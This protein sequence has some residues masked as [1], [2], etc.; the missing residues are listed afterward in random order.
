MGR[1]VC[2]MNEYTLQG[3]LIPNS[4]VHISA[5]IFDETRPVIRCTCEVYNF[6]Q[7]I[8]PD[9]NLE[10]SHTTSCM[11]CRFFN[12]HLLNAY[13]VISEG[14]PHLPRPLQIIKGSIQFM[15]DEVLLLGD[16][17]PSGTT[18]YSVNGKE[19]FSIINLNFTGGICYV[20]CNSGS[21]CWFKHKQEE[22]SKENEFE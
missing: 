3:H 12:D 10:L 9:D 8:E 11:H 18:K 21:L 19:T 1:N 6:L 17:N 7:N 15:N 22:N 5:E 20:K 2:V 4:F 16:I 13:E 14:H